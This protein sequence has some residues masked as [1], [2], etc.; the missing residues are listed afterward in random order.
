MMQY[1]R[2]D[3]F[4]NL[5]TLHIFIT[6][7]VLA[8]NSVT[9]ITFITHKIGCSS[10]ISSRTLESDLMWR[11][12]TPNILQIV[13]VVW[14]KNLCQTGLLQSL[15]D[16]TVRIVKMTN[17]IGT[18]DL[19]IT[20]HHLIW[21]LCP[22]LQRKSTKSYTSLS[23]FHFILW[24]LNCSSRGGQKADELFRMMRGHLLHGIP[25]LDPDHSITESVLPAHRVK[26][27]MISMQ[28]SSEE[29]K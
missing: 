14:V 25:R 1:S 3:N 11:I 13:Y 9:A 21:L 22:L 7:L 28:C 10:V 12:W 18:A 24:N 29:E 8:M 23:N 26:K 4:Q 2:N 17:T 19:N 20:W 16:L 5:M 27:H 15:H 6:V